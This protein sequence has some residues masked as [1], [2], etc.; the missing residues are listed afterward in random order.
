MKKIISFILIV[1]VTLCFCACSKKTLDTE[2]STKLALDGALNYLGM[3]GRGTLF[4]S[5]TEEDY[6]KIDNTLLKSY[7]GSEL[8]SPKTE[9]MVS[10]SVF[11]SFDKY[12]TEVGV[13]HMSDEATASP[14]K[15]FIE[16]R[17]A[18]LLELAKQ[19]ENAAGVKNLDLFSVKTDGSFVYYLIGEGTYKAL[20][21]IEK[22]LY[23]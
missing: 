15:L 1:S 21:E 22:I 19:E 18:K 11:F 13:F 9:E 17:R 20:E 16:V 10:Y 23:K 5:E 12:G 4:F 7:Y 8:G 14:M 2:A 3:T 6:N